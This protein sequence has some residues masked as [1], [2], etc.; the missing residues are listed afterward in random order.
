MKWFV[1]DVL[2]VSSRHESRCTKM[3]V[4]HS[5]SCCTEGNLVD[6]Q[7]GLYSLAAA[8]TCSV[9]DCCHAVLTADCSALCCQIAAA[10]AAATTTSVV[11]VV[12]VVVTYS[13]VIVTVMSS[14]TNEVNEM[15]NMAALK[16][17]RKSI[18]R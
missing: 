11:V 2:A 1:A 17:C 8:E 5:L 13:I 12:V 14:I 7:M 3:L 9:T 10:A 6:K 15:L 16:K 4:G 18:P